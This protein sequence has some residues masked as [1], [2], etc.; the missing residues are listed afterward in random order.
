MKNT[1]KFRLL[2]IAGVALSLAVI[3]CGEKRTESLDPQMVVVKKQHVIVDDSN[4]ESWYSAKFAVDVPVEGPQPLIDSLKMFL[5]KELYH[6]FES[7]DFEIKEDSCLLAF[8]EVYTDDLSCLLDSYA[9]KYA[10]HFK[11][12]EWTWPGGL[13][14]YMIAQTES[15][16]TYGLESWMGRGSSM[17]CHTFSKKDGHK[18]GAV[19][20]EDNLLR[21]H[22]D[23]PDGT[24]LDNPN[25][26]CFDMGLLEDGVLGIN[27]CW[28]NHYFTKKFNYNRELLTYLTEEAQEMINSKGITTY[29]Y[30]EWSLGEDIGKVKTTGG[31]TFYLMQRTPLWDETTIFDEDTKK[32]YTLTAYIMQDGHYV[33]N[34]EVLYPHSRMEFEFPECAWSGPEALRE[35]VYFIFDNDSNILYVPH[36][37]G[38]CAMEYEVYKFNGNRFDYFRIEE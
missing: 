26:E 22:N 38:L 23:H 2:L 10:D 16:V 11:E 25:M 21:F 19:I 28:Q 20:T 27:R 13:S 15:F 14:L 32:T 3:G 35:D 24:I 4:P 36:R 1:K 17:Y 7:F 37:K 34:D 18:I 5:N 29:A 8:E 9:H 12:M 6:A 30:D 33:R 31:E